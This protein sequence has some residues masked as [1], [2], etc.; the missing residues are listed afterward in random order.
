MGSRTRIEDAEQVCGGNPHR[1]PSTKC[2]TL[3]GWEL[4][5]TIII[6]TA[7]VQ[8][9]SSCAQVSTL[10]TGGCPAMLLHTSYSVQL[11]IKFD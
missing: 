6:L 11:D 8:R 9:S 5:M 4:A 1:I 7:Q 2:L 3:Y 10:Q